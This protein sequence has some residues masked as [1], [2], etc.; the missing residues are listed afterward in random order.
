MS[1]TL[2][3]RLLITLR[4]GQAD[5]VPWNI[6]DGSFRPLLVHLARTDLPVIE[7]FTPLPVGDVTVAEALAAWPQ[8]VIW[9]SFPG[10]L[11]FEPAEVIEAYAVELLR[12]GAA[13][14]RLI[15]DCTEEFPVDAF[16]KTFTAIGRALAPQGEITP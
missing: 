1:L 16:D 6:Y 9:E 11:F 13:S 12:Q 8:K 5:R 3:E 2:R 4:S 10:C 7:A 15:I 14:G